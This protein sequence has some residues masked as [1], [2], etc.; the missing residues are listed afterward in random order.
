MNQA[1]QIIQDLTEAQFGGK[2][3]PKGEPKV[4]V[5]RK[6]SKSLEYF[7]SRNTQVIVPAENAKQARAIIKRSGIEQKLEI[8]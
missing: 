6:K 1:Q 3:E 4:A 8:R 7:N 2:G 5:F